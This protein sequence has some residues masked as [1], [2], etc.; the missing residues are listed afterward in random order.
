M[1]SFK[2]LSSLFIYFWF[3]SRIRQNRNVHALNGNVDR[4]YKRYG[5]AKQIANPIYCDKCGID[6]KDHDSD[7]CDKLSPALVEVCKICYNPLEGHDENTCDSQNLCACGQSY[8]NHDMEVH[9]TIIQLSEAVPPVESPVIGSNKLVVCHGCGIQVRS[10]KIRSHRKYRCS[11][12]DTSSSGSSSSNK[13]PNKIKGSKI[14]RA[15]DPSP[16]HYIEES[17]VSSDSPSGVLKNELSLRKLEIEKETLANRRRTAIIKSETEVLSASDD[18]INADRQLSTSTNKLARGVHRDDINVTRFCVPALYTVNQDSQKKS[19]LKLTVIIAIFYHL[20]FSPSTALRA[21]LWVLYFIVRKVFDVD[22]KPMLPYLQFE[23]KRSHVVGPVDARNDAHGFHDLT[24]AS[25]RISHW[26]VKLPHYCDHHEFCRPRF[27]TRL[28]MKF[29]AR[30][31]GTLIDKA[32]D[33]VLPIFPSEVD[34]HP[35]AA[36]NTIK[37]YEDDPCTCNADTVD[38]N[39]MD[40]FA[41]QIFPNML[42]SDDINVVS[43][44]IRT[45]IKSHSGTNYNRMEAFSEDQFNG[46]EKFLTNWF[47]RNKFN[48]SGLNSDEILVGNPSNVLLKDFQSGSLSLRQAPVNPS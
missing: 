9:D 38:I 45:G 8:N 15:R 30:N 47:V 10:N 42:R 13:V 41:A 24:H 35:F 36:R 16:S 18:K 39:V 11:S 22:R 17:S 48:S 25:Q 31:V 34:P 44:L 6:M 21:M 20:M 29:G 19:V 40:E 32:V 27:F 2:I 26:S 4:K 14:K 12:S 28:F 3:V 7:T 1:Y 43:A 46:T 23:M 37:Q 33:Y 5:K